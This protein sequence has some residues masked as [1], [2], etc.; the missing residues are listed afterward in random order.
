MDT[1]FPA[2][3]AEE[4]KEHGKIISDSFYSN[5]DLSVLHCLAYISCIYEYIYIY[6][7]EKT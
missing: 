7:Q 6:I 3:S 5:L 4:L 1:H 2:A